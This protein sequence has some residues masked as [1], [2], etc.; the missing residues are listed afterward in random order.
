M[1]SKFKGVTKAEES[2]ENAEYRIMIPKIV[3]TK[4]NEKRTPAMRT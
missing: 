3:L 1:I 4:K 2:K